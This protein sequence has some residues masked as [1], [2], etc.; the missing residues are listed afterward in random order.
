MTI[1]PGSARLLAAALLLALLGL[2]ELLVMVC[3]L[4]WVFV[5]SVL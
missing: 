5:S 1:S 2:W 3:G 4:C